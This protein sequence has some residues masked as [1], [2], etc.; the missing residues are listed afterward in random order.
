MSDT[1]IHTR[2]TNQINSQSSFKIANVK[3]VNVAGNLTPRNNFSRPKSQSLIA[4]IVTGILLTLYVTLDNCNC[5]II[6]FGELS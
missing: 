1:I 3:K 6:I 2:H 4:L 5:M